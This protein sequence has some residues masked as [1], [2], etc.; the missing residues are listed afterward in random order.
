MKGRKI[1]VK[2]VKINIFKFCK[3]NKGLKKFKNC[4]FKNNC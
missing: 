1:L 2:M 3:L 4:L